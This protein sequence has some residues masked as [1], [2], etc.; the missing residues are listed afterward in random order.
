MAA[1][2]R[3]EHIAMELRS[4][5]QDAEHL[6]SGKRRKDATGQV[7]AQRACKA[8]TTVRVHVIASQV[9]TTAPALRPPS[10]AFGRCGPARSARGGRARH[11]LDHL[12]PGECTSEMA[13]DCDGVSELGCEMRSTILN[14]V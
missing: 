1:F 14:Q 6:S 8:L 11:A 2:E 7:C 10:G 5:R 12:R 13:P 9:P 4:A 3:L